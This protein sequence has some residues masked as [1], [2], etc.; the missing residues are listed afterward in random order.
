MITSSRS[1]LTELLVYPTPTQAKSQVKTSARVLTSAESI[2]ILE[3]K[4]KKA[5]K[6]IEEKEKRKEERQRKKAA[7][8]EDK[9]HKAREREMKKVAQKKLKG[10]KQ[11]DSRFDSE[12]TRL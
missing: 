3:E 11:P 2:A 6:E 5:L 4:Q 7:K 8:E 1:P 9:Q 10:K 12:D